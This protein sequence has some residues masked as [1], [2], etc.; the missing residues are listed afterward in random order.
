MPTST[1]PDK[2]EAKEGSSQMDSDDLSSDGEDME[3][4]VTAVI[5]KATTGIN[6]V[7]YLPE[8]FRPPS[9]VRIAESMAQLSVMPQASQVHPCHSYMQHHL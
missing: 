5:K 3:E 2:E 1:E 4:K 8:D 9:C 6:M 7:F